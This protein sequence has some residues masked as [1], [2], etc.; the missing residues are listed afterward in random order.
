M[1]ETNFTTLDWGLVISYLAGT[2][3]FGMY[4]N[5]HIHSAEDY[6]VGG[7]GS[8]AALNIASF[9]GTGLGLVTLMYASIEG[10]NRGFAFLFIPLL[11]MIVPLIL[12]ATGFVISHLRQ[13]KLTTIPEYFEHR[14]NRKVRVVAGVICAL[15]GILNMGLF[16]KMGATFI[17]F[18]TGMGGSDAEMT[19]NIITSLLILLV[20]AYTVTGGMVAVIVTDY[21]Q[22]LILSLGLGLGLFYCFFT[23]DIGWERM[24]HS[25]WQRK[26]EAGFNPVHPQSYGWTY[27]GMMVLVQVAAGICWVPEATRA[28][29]T[30]DVA[31]TNRTF[32]WGSPGFFARMAIPALWGIAA[33]AFF[34]SHSTLSMHF[35]AENL[36]SGA[37]HASQ[38]MPLF[39]GK[40]IP[41]G[42]LG[43]LVA[44]LM[45]AFMSTHDSY[46]LAWASV[47]SQDVVAPLRGEKRL[48]DTQSILITRICVVVIGA[49]LLV[50]G[51]W[52]QLPESVW[53][54]MAITGTIYLS[55]TATALVGGMYWKRASS[56]GALWAI[57]GG[58]SCLPVLFLEPIQRW[59]AGVPG[60]VRDLTAEQTQAIEK[61]SYYL[62]DS[63][64][65]LA[66]YGLCLLLFIVGSLLFPDNAADTME[67]LTH[68]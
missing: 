56:T 32:F 41:A 39:L 1:F 28:L 14:Y 49:F 43:L 55:G 51:I 4:V 48:T 20:L 34:L 46:L 66:V 40:A 59:L 24:V 35:S 16:P 57:L 36:S 50:W 26:G 7:R 30:K 25:V 62:N 68:A 67:E 33:A 60:S 23:T 6:L 17:T 37:A 12:G 21:V 18:V 54:Y 42:F 27:V 3:A 44:G 45:A 11:G 10:F 52:Y 13:M 61:V 47:I 5:R 64:I 19:V 58:L 53:T 31:T 38:A 22:F 8:G 29:T 15:A 9:I 2:A 63:S 65:A